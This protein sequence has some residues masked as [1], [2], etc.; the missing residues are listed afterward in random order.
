METR[1]ARP[2]R[3]GSWVILRWGEAMVCET[4]SHFL[5][6]WLLIVLDYS[7]THM[8][9][10]E[11]TE[12]VMKKGTKCPPFLA[13]RAEGGCEAHIVSGQTQTIQ[14]LTVALWI[15]LLW[16]RII[17]TDLYK[18]TLREQK[19]R[20][21]Y[22]CTKFQKA[23]KQYSKMKGISKWISIRCYS[24]DRCLHHEII[25]HHYTGLPLAGE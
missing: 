21:F 23:S 18:L 7:V 2:G 17:Q 5:L 16:E 1:L 4:A 8:M 6:R 25:L 24:W 13:W 19:T 3:F 10:S 14:K 11:K 12:P 15:V 20:F 9:C 22:L